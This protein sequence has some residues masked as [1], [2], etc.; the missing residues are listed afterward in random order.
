MLVKDCHVI[1]DNATIYIQLVDS[2]EC[3]DWNWLNTEELTEKFKLNVDSSDESAATV[4][5]DALLDVQLTQFN[6][7]TPL[8]DPLVAFE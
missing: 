5:G 2:I 4:A 7:F 8:T 1:P 6:E 3:R